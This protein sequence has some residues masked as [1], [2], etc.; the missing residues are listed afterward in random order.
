MRR[1][2][3]LARLGQRL[4]VVRRPVGYPER[5]GDDPGAGRQLEKLRHQL[6]DVG[7]QQ[8]QRQHRRL[9]DVGRVH[10]ALREGR[11]V[12][13]AGGG[14]LPPRELDEIG[15]ELDA[16]TARAAFGGGDDGAAVARAEID[17]EVLRRDLGVVEH[18]LDHGCARRH[19][20]RILAHLPDDRLVGLLLGLRPER[21]G[22]RQDGGRRPDALAIRTREHGSSNENRRTGSRLGE[23]GNRELD[24]FIL[25]AHRVHRFTGS[26]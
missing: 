6:L 5:V 9:R 7:R 21:C 14:R 3:V 11:L 10:V 23:P 4:S 16:E 13:H 2:P 26:S 22:Q 20:D 8:E 25:R 18:L 19:P 1:A 17:D 12:G 15:V 24:D